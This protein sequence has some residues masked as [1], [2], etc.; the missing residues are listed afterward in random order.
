MHAASDGAR[1]A[2]GRSKFLGDFEQ[3]GFKV[4]RLGILISHCQKNP[5]L[6]IQPCHVGLLVAGTLPRPQVA[7]SQ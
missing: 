6:E 2:L 4:A 7:G 3:Y 1:R 5:P